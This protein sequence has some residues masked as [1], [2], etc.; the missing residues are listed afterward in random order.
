M[1]SSNKFLIGIVIGAVLLISASI[2]IV[3]HKPEPTYQPED[4][5]GGVAH[6]Y[7]LALQNE[8]YDRAYTYLSS[9]L[10]GYPA[11]VSQFTESIEDY[12]WYFQ[13]GT[14]TTLAVDTVEITGSKAVI[15]V[16]ETRFQNRGLFENST[17]ISTFEMDLKKVGD[18]WKIV[19]SDRYFVWCWGNESGCRY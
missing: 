15:L 11:T 9:T 13:L 16:R 19:D 12:S 5:P 7:L 14:D 4:T 8:D 10:P 17:R 18:Q 2:I 6:N 1:K 3:L